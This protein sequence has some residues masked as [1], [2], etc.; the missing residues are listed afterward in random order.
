MTNEYKSYSILHQFVL[1]N[2]LIF[3]LLPLTREGQVKIMYLLTNACNYGKNQTSEVKQN[4]CYILKTDI[5]LC[6]TTKE[7]HLAISAF[8]PRTKILESFNRYEFCFYGDC[9]MINNRKKALFHNFVNWAKQLH[10]QFCSF[11]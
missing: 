9:K 8:F 11:Y 6:F 4:C 1:M 2:I 10:V 3:A 5:L 7:Q